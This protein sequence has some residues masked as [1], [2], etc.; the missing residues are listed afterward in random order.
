MRLP[1]ELKQEICEV[2]KL[3]T[4]RILGQVSR[5]WYIISKHVSER[6]AWVSLRRAYRIHRANGPSYPSLTSIPTNIE[7]TWKNDLYQ[8]TGNNVHSYWK[9]TNRQIIGGD[10][11]DALFI[12]GDDIEKVWIEIIAHMVETSN[13]IVRLWTSY[14]SKTKYVFIKLPFIIP[15][16][17]LIYT[18]PHVYIRSNGPTR[19]LFRS[20]YISYQDCR[21]L[22]AKL[23]IVEIEGRKIKFHYFVTAE[24][25][26]V[27]FNSTFPPLGLGWN[28]LGWN[29][30]GSNSF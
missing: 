22:D 19:I 10:V 15:L 30:L 21:D 6:K 27:D 29:I 9:Q 1:L 25:S 8:T 13:N 18:P 23:H 26:E 24:V 2:L 28:G 5:E 3:K 4:L 12:I 14:H 20:G 16:R 11:T 17:S 7:S